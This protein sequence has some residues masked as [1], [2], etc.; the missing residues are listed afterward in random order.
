[1]T[2]VKRIVIP[3]LVAAALSVAANLRAAE[4]L[5][6]NPQLDYAS[7]SRDGP[8]INGD[9]LDEGTVSGKPNYVFMFGEG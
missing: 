3:A 5:R 7:D 2:R 6:L 4:N 1:M 8:L 9:H